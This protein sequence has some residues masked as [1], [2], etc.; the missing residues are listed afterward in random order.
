MT[1]VERVT[2][3]R[4]TL[5]LQSVHGQMEALAEGSKPVPVLDVRAVAV[6]LGLLVE[7]VEAVA[8]TVAV[9]DPE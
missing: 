3:A 2:L 6:I 1:T 5:A 7:K 8:G 9:V 4:L